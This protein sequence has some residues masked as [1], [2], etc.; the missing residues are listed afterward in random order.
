MAKKHKNSITTGIGDE[1][2][3]RTLGGEMISKADPIIEAC[4]ALDRLR[5]QTALLRLQ[6]EEAPSAEDILAMGEMLGLDPDEDLPEE[7]ESDPGEYVPV[8]DWLLSLYFMM[9]AAISDPTR[10]SPKAHHGGVTADHIQD[11]EREQGELEEQCD[12][13]KGFIIGA[14]NQLAAH[15]D[16]VATLARDLERS[17][18]RLKETNPDFTDQNVLIFVNRLSDYFYML[19]RV[20]EEGNH[21]YVAYE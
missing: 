14:S 20:L 2:Q 17:L 13:P 7:S 8:L 18:A 4:G 1:G 3:T 5:A 6:L 9:G 19:A 12:I 15:A 16:I 10:K 21:Q 11:I